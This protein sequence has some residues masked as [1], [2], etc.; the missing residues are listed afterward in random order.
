MANEDL[1]SDAEPAKRPQYDDL[2][3]A[4][5]KTKAAANLRFAV[6]V[7]P[8]QAARDTT[9]ARRYNMPPAA[10]EMFREDFEVRAKVDDG[11]AVL[12]QRPRLRS[13]IAEDPE[14]AKVAHDDLDAMGLLEAGAKYLVGAKEAPRGGLLT[15]VARA[16]R[17]VASG[18]PSLSAGLYGGVAAVAGLSDQFVQALDDAAAWVTGTPQ[19]QVMGTPGPES[20]LR[21]QQR[22][23]N[24][25]ASNWMGLDPA[26]GETERAVMSGFQSAGSNLL[27]LPAGF[28]RNGTNIMLGLMGTSVGGQSY[29]KGRDAG[30][31]PLRATGYAVQDATAE[32]VM[33]RYFG[34]AG[35][36]KNIK[37]GASAGKLFAYEVFKEVPG[38]VATTIW[39]NF[40]EWANLHPDKSLA[41]F[42]EEQP[43]AIRDTIIATLVGGTTQIGAVKGV[44]RVLG[45]AA[46][47]E[48]KARQS[49]AMA[50][51][52]GN[53]QKTAEASKLLERSPDN[54][55]SYMQSLVEDDVPEVYVD[56]A[57]L[58]EAG[59]DLTQLAQALPSVAEQLTEVA[60]GGDLVIP[61]SELLVNTI[62]TE[63]AQALI[64]N[65]RVREDAMSRTEAK[66]WM[67]AKGEEI[68]S[69]V[70]RTLAE[71]EQNA[72]WRKNRDD[73]Q[74]QILAQ[75]NALGRFDAKVN[76]RNALLAAQ[77][78]AVTAAQLG[79]TPQ[80]LAQQYRLNWTGE[81]QAQTYDQAGQF[82]VESTDWQEVALGEKKATFT[83]K[84]AGG[85]TAA[86]ATL[87]RMPNGEIQIS[88][89]KTEEGHRSKGM[90]TRLVDEVFR[91]TGAKML[92]FS[93][94]TT[95]DGT[96]FFEKYGEKMIDGRR[97]VMRPARVDSNILHQDENIDYADPELGIS[98]VLLE[99]GKVDS[100]FQ[101]PKSEAKDIESI[102]KNKGLLVS[103]VN[104]NS[105]D[106]TLWML[107][108]TTPENSEDTHSWIV[109]I[110]ESN[111]DATVTRKGDEVYI[112]VSAIG[113]GN[114][115]SAIYDLAANYAF[116]NGL[117]FIGDPNGVSA[118]AMRRRLENMLSAAIK[119]GTTDFLAPH[120]D[121]LQGNEKL[122][123]PPLRWTEGDTLGNI[124][125]MV[126]VSVAATQELNPNA[127]LFVHFD[128]GS[129]SFVGPEGDRIGDAELPGMLGFDGREKGLGQGGNTTVQR[130][131]IFRAL[132]AGPDERRALLESIRREQAGGGQGLGAATRGTFYQGVN[133][134]DTRFSRGQGNGI[135]MADAK[136]AVA[137][138]R[139]AL[140]KAPAIHLYE[141]L[142]K[143][144]SAVVEA[145]EQQG[146]R[147]DVEAVYHGSEIHAFPGNFESVERLMFVVGHHEVRH[148][149][150]RTLLGPDL[151]S[152]MLALYENEA[153]KLAAD[154]KMAAG[155]SSRVLAVEEALADM[156]A[157]QVAS[158]SGFDKVVAAIRQWL[159]KF[160]DGLRTRGFASFADAIEPD[161]WTDNDVAALVSKAEDVSRY[162]R[163]G[164][165]AGGTAFS[166][167]Y[168]QDARGS[169]A[170]GEDITKTPSIISVLEKADLSTI[171]HELGH[172]F[173]EMRFDLAV[174]MEARARAGET[175]TD[176]ERQILDDT[177]RALDWL[178]VRDTPELTAIE[179]WLTMSVDEKRPYHEKLARAHEAY[180]FEGKAPSLELQ[181]LFQTFRS[182]LLNVYRA[183]LKTMSAGPG[184]IGKALNVE[185]TDEFRQVMDRM[186]ATAEQI[187]EAEAA[188]NMGPLFQTAEEAGMTPAEYEAYQRLGIRASLDAQ[189]ELQAKSLKDLQWL[190]NARSRVLKELQRQH[191]ALRRDV[192]AQVRVEVMAQPVYQAWAFLTK[193]Q[194]DKV[195]GDDAA[196]NARTLNPEVDNLFTAIAKLGGLDREAVQKAWGIDPKEKIESGVFGMP[197]LRKDGGL[198]LD[199]MAERLMEAGY[200]LPDENGKADLAKFEEVFD[201]QRRGTDR[202][203]IQRDLAAA[204]G[205]PEVVIPDVPDTGYGRLRTEDL[206]RMYGMGDNAIWRVLSKRRMTSD[207]GG[208]SPEV[209]AAMF[210]DENGDPVFDSGDA[211]VRALATAEPPRDVIERLTDARMLQ[212]HAEV[213]APGALER[214][215]EIAVHNEARAKFVATELGALQ[216]AVTVR[217]KVPG[218]RNTVDVLAQ[219][220]KDYAKGIIYRKRVRDLRPAQYAAAEA[221][222]ARAAAKAKGDMVK[223]AEHKRN[224]LVNL[225]A[226]KAAYQAQAEIEAAL[227]YFRRVA[228]PGNVPA[229]HH[230]Q[231]MALLDKFDLSDTP[232]KALDNRDRFR[233]W[234]KKQLDSGLIP[235]N[236][237]MLLTPEQRADF[238][239]QLQSRNEDGELAYPNEED[240]ALLLAGYIDEM[241]VRN[242]RD[243]TVEEIL[244]LRDAVRQ[245]E[246][247]GR[248]TK[249]VL[250]D[251]KNR[252]FEAVVTSMRQRIEDVA[253]KM[254]RKAGDTRTPNDTTGQS[255]L[256]WRGFFFSHVKAANLL[257]IMD[258]E[259]GGPLWEHLMATANEAANGE[260]IDLAMAH[261]AIQQLLKPVKDLGGITDKAIHFPSIGRSLNRQ[262]RLVMALN[263]GNESNTQR[264]LGGESWTMEQIKPVLDTLTAA[265]WQFVQGMW[266]HY[267]SYRPRVAEMER[268]INGVE[269]EWIKARPITVQ[270]ADGQTLTLRGGYAPVIYDPRASGKAASFAAEKDAK[271]MMQAARVASTVSKSFTKARVDEVKGR[272]LLLSLDAMIGAVQDTVHYLHWQPWIIDAN[273][274]IKA[275]DE[276]IRTYYGAE[277]VTQLRHWA[278]DNA[279][280]MAPVRDAAERLSSK[281]AR[282]VSYT[283][284]AFN[285][286]SAV[287]Q[288]TGYS[289]SVVVVGAKWMGRGVARSIQ[290]PRAAYLEAVEKSDFLKKRATTRMRDL[291][292]VNATVQDQGVV[293][294]ALDR[295]AYTMML[296][297]QTAVDIPTWWGAY[298]KAID[299]GKDEQTAVAMADQAVIDAQGSGLRKDLAGYEREV[300]A[301]RLFTGFM[302][303]MNT[304]MNVNYRVLKSDQS[305]GAKAMDLMLVNAVP[306][307][308]SVLIASALV[309]GGE[310]DPEKL[311]KKYLTEQ[312]SFILGQ[313]LWLRELGQII[314]AFNGEPSGQY[315]GPVGM[316]AIADTMK[317]AKQV[318]QGE[319]DEAAVKAGV[320][321]AGD[322]F[323]LPSAQINRTIT[324]SKAVAEGQTRSAP[325]SVAAPVFGFHKQ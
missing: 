274:M 196:G 86:R 94:G 241:P 45:G 189:D 212:E 221:R 46:K 116:N 135:P 100:L 281:L 190:Q 122:G 278:G 223:A 52:L 226:T 92:R 9:L 314:A 47:E 142:G 208:L 146:A 188:R 263:L 30:L 198:G 78:Y 136:A 22:I 302:S 282:N 186:L 249:K 63:F 13:W 325:A 307:M 62:G 164:Y 200:L 20:F 289:Q 211:L 118:A 317:L 23:A 199:A 239:R 34:A 310:D 301:I 89:I 311:A 259:A 117:K 296:A 258:G 181:G 99:L 286:V 183:L 134:T 171:S 320:S 82:A 39:Q 2:F 224:Q 170:F 158:L 275:L 174:R 273:R 270:T 112:N 309:P 304:T 287:K 16:A 324:G 242:Y 153:V 195:E 101:Y 121:Q 74:Q 33:E 165:S 88:D 73:L 217:E 293:R 133:P 106:N 139:K 182:W 48:E 280:G 29:G 300:G 104:R 298:E 231:I 119:Y 204:Y 4:D 267:E 55:R 149:G 169:V 58:Q 97:A 42:I 207:D 15:D 222:A 7:N 192:R 90:A 148:H 156:P 66:A 155:V 109:T 19:R 53:L 276:P 180:L 218:Q 233:T 191:D 70:E 175:L 75:L 162:G 61:T 194:F 284:L 232:L 36:L 246:H 288:V 193:R 25:V 54:L 152:L 303:F 157:D 28:A 38:E 271:A 252:E 294:K 10:A 44:Q 216:K 140:P 8:D 322:I 85:K 163:A 295:Y 240:Q 159:R 114:G 108:N 110:P 238:S 96:A 323:R 125:A 229:T 103:E 161:K 160:A 35:L 143:A 76:E 49:D 260:V 72:E 87:Y 123:I 313:M 319:L 105:T 102:A 18:A 3:D 254:G 130:N 141:S 56:S 219:A 321:V 257:H 77:H 265:N 299:G 251:R 11:M 132:L 127:T 291:A 67:E 43:A 83:V 31:D 40:N 272:P 178:D 176:G 247:I 6:P 277:V 37:A 12:E 138:I 120:P 129:Q 172:F 279:A 269:P 173:W 213:A 234:A 167:E 68:R 248:R 84:D 60:T 256:S 128:P 214:A 244:G 81:Q 91:K 262:A 5:P 26:A 21:D 210:T 197:V 201:D 206:R 292:E 111:K 151:N 290:N 71:Q 316:R 126:D 184:D 41:D 185:L 243:A 69:S 285:V 283:G 79:M 145:I 95:A 237:D 147:D 166:R 80:Q 235:P 32:I 228:K 312:A 1:F 261:D 266:D 220:A 65:A 187:A 51:A 59:L 50:K 131:A 168:Q 115:G 318:G 144:P 230:D 24:T 306:A 215:A 315:G 227:Q 64:D 255:R 305:V 177:Y 253:E 107:A 236:V 209:V 113:E 93:A 98:R 250:T 124:R 308:L 297:M 203:S 179:H 154:E 205:E 57:R 27:T 264:L 14:R 17:A 268:L 245:I 150:L 202:Y 137:L 225:H